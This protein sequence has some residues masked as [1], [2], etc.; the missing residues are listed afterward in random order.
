MLG[1]AETG[2][3]L[4]QMLSSAADRGQVVDGAPHPQAGILPQSGKV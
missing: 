2:R 3:L 4:A 1:V